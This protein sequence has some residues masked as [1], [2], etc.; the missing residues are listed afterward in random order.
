MN[1]DNERITD[2]P[3]RQVAIT[4]DVDI[5][6]RT[7]QGGE[8]SKTQHG[9]SRVGGLVG[10]RILVDGVVSL[11]YIYD[12]AP[13]PA[14]PVSAGDVVVARIRQVNAAET[15]LTVGQMIGLA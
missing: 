12:N 3:G 13:G 7:K 11:T 4:F 2:L 6:P 5:D 10:L 1:P 14:F 9:A 8:T 15:T